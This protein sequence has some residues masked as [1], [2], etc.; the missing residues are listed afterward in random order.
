[1]FSVTVSQTQIKPS[2]FSCAYIE[3]WMQSGS[4]RSTQ[5]A[6]VLLRF[7][8]KCDTILMFKHFNK[9]ISLR[10]FS[11]PELSNFFLISL[12]FKR[13]TLFTATEFKTGD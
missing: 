1:M 10:T 7:S 2:A 13:F 11:R 9:N 8:I 5:D 3:I 12:L 4:L 6:R